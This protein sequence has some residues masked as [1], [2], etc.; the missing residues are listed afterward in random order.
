M[1]LFNLVSANW[2]FR[3]EFVSKFQ[4][5]QRTAAYLELHQVCGTQPYRRDPGLTSRVPAAA[6]LRDG[7]HH[8]A[9][10]V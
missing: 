3:R 7:I 5:Q 1:L 6:S 4:T 9:H 2:Q 10:G 8:L